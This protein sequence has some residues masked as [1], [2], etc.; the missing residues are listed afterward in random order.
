MKKILLF[1]VVMVSVV[2]F[3]KAQTPISLEKNNVPL[4]AGPFHY[5]VGNPKNT[6]LPKNGKNISWDYSGLLKDTGFSESYQFVFHNPFSQSKLA[7]TDTG[8][9]EFLTSS[10]F[11]SG[12]DFFDEDSNGFYFSG[13][14]V[15]EQG[16]S[17]KNY[18]NNSADS[19]YI[20]EQDDSLR[21]DLINFPSIFG[22]G[23]HEKTIKSLF[24]FW[25]V[26]S[27]NMDSAI[28]FK[29][30]YY[31]V[32][33]T[34]T[35]WGTL[36]V[37]VAGK[38]SIAYTVL[39][40]Q[41][42]VVTIDSYFVNGSPANKFF[43]IAF[44][45]VQGQSIVDCNEYFYRTGHQEP[46]LAIGFGTDTS[47]SAPLS[48]SWSTDSIT[49]QAGINTN[50]PDNINFS[51]YPNPV[52]ANQ[53]NWSLAKANGGQWQILVLNSLGQVFRSE[54]IEGN[55]TINQSFDISGAKAGLYFVAVLDENGQLLGNS[56]LNITR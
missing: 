38:K 53:V 45:M 4:S 24:F 14:S 9:H 30:T 3:V 6:S 16:L 49:Q 32:S 51:L 54:T 13:A 12:T 23:H 55:G 20:P 44:G 2:C 11:F 25:T 43:L 31:S 19:I 46:L 50:D 47:Y 29:T 48:V 35:G 36:R 21:L 42:K 39:L 33:D 15:A 28:S 17:L 5:A 37:P 10:N 41:R 18:F 8:I 1:V 40:I 56:K 7:L 22:K 27:A 26:K 34:V 52:N